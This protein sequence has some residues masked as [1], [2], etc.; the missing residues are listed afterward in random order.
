[1]NPVLNPLPRV[2]ELADEVVRLCRVDTGAAWQT[3]K[4]ALRIAEG[5]TE[6]RALAWAVRALG[7]VSH[8]AD[9]NVQAV[10]YYDRASRLFHE[11]GDQLEDARTLSSLV[12]PLAMLGQYERSLACAASARAMFE[13]LG[14]IARIARLEINLGNVYHRQDRFPEALQCYVSALGGIDSRQDPEACAVILSNQATTLISMN[15]FGEALETYRRARDFCASQNM[16]LL[17]AQADY[18]IAWLHYLRGRYS[19]AM[20]MLHRARASFESAEGAF[21]LGLCDLDESEICLELNLAADARRLARRA[22]ERFL[23][24]G[25][26]Y[27]LA[28]SLVCEARAEHAAGDSAKALGLLQQ[29]SLLFSGEANESWVRIVALYQSLVHLQSSS[30]ALALQPA[31]DA[32]KFFTRQGAATRAIF[33]GLLAARAYF[34]TGDPVRAEEEIRGALQSLEGLEAPWLAFHGHLLGGKISL[35][36]GRTGAARQAYRAAISALN[37]MRHSIRFDEIKIAFVQDKVE[38]FETFVLLCLEAAHEDPALASDR[39]KALLQEAF[40]A[41][42]ASKSRSQANL[43]ARAATTPAAAG[44]ALSRRIEDLR[45]ELNGCYRRLLHREFRKDAPCSPEPAG[46]LHEIRSREDEL[47]DALRRLPAA[48]QYTAV[49]KPPASLKEIQECLPPDTQLVEFFKAEDTVL[50]AI[51]GRDHLQFFPGLSLASRVERSLRLFRFQ[52][53]RMSTGEPD[54]SEEIKGEGSLVH[55]ESLYHLLI[56]PLAAHLTAEHLV[57][58]PH[59]FLHGLP[60]HALHEKGRFLGDRYTIS[61]APSATLLRDCLLRRPASGSHSLLLEAQDEGLSHVPREIEELRGLLPEA[62]VARGARPGMEALRSSGATARFLHIAGHG[63]FRQEHP[64]F[65]SI[66]L[67]E[68]SLTLL[69]LYGMR[70]NC[71]LATLSGCGTGRSAVLAGDELVGLTRGFFFAGAQSLLVSL[72]AVDDSTTARFM[73]AFYA[74]VCGG[75]P[76]AESLRSAVQA[77]RSE[78]RHP[79]YWAPFFLVG[80]P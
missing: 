77:V 19:Q 28:K 26:S 33:A 24:V 27:E 59:G 48:E 49:E 74:Q 50:A 8:I 71:E 11:A 72:W 63:V 47:L 17:V 43:I 7:N 61:Y 65:S 12:M 29:A 6:P 25:T 75:R 35:W 76:K 51:I 21:H 38:A 78:K 30:P 44:D 37:A 34:A 69:D 31:L 14:E 39:G 15:R 13:R 46:L 62:E 5:S 36:R 42:E 64:L 73:S 40:G 32:K 68:G 79:Y 56:A 45:E 55:L 57:I 54:V 1:M 3:A 9:R 41:I 66:Q 67:G 60:F 16:T 53:S 18:N 4:E 80:K 2:V 58:V 20:E 10:E 23:Q 70:L 52:I 22:G